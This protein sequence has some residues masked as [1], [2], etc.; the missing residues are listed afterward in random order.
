[1]LC[2]LGLGDIGGALATRALALGMRV[3]GVRRGGRAFPGLA[4]TYTPD[5]LLEALP[6]A[7]HVA[8]CLPLT[9]ET[10]AI[11]G[12]REFVAMRPTAYIYNVGRGASIDPDAL[13]RALQ[14][15]RI[16]GAGLD[17]TSP[18]PLPDDSPLWDMP[19]VILTQHVS[20]DSPY[21]AHRIT[22]IFA[23]NLRRYLA[24]EPLQNLVDKA[25]GY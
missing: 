23:D 25:R 6:Q 9:S 8:L 15:G 14:S 12:E 11:V 4:A 20:G 22:T 13:L 7:D 3:V 5:R 10:R 1:V 19:N 21:N 18:E 24:G 17:V 16:A 2:V